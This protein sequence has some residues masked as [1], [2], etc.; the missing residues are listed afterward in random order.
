MF[1]QKQPGFCG[2]C[3][4]EGQ[5]EYNSPKGPALCSTACYEE[6]SWRYTLYVL[7]KPYYVK[8]QPEFR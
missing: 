3:G 5:Y 1:F 2:V 8:Q 7:G 4:K 6:A